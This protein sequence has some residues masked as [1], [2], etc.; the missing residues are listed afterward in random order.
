MNEV[1]ESVSPLITNNGTPSNLTEFVTTAVTS[2]M[3]DVH[4]P[5][6]PGVIGWMLYLIASLIVGVTRIFVWTLSFATITIPTLIF[7]ILSVSF[8]L[9][10]NFSSLYPPTKV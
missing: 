1:A 9:T 2:S 8:T 5:S 10:L 6:S 3:E 4:P 7:K